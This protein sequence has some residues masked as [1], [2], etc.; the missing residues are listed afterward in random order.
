MNTGTFCL[1]YPY[2][3]LHTISTGRSGL[4]FLTMLGT[5]LGTLNT[6]LV[7]TM[8]GTERWLG[9]CKTISG[10]GNKSSLNLIPSFE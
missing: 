8:L 7:L 2:A 9:Q 1:L 10:C 4:P 3:S 5:L 6:S